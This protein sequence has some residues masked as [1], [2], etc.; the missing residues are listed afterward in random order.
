M[1]HTMQIICA[2]LKGECPFFQATKQQ[3]YSYTTVKNE[4]VPDL[5]QTLQALN[6]LQLKLIKYIFIS[7]CLIMLFQVV[8]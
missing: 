3:H 5:F 1:I 6:I 8:A 2:N 4:N 7:Q